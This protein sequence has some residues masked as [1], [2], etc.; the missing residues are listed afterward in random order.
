M[1]AYSSISGK[2]HHSGS[3]DAIKQANLALL[4]DCGVDDFFVGVNRDL[5]QKLIDAKIPHDYIERP[6]QHSWQYWVRA[7]PYHLFFFREQFA[8]Q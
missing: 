4:I 1:K 3:I 8:K 5:H 6:G 2:K 7:L